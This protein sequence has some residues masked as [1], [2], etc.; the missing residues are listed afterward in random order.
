MSNAIVKTK[1]SQK[2]QVFH[3]D[4][5]AMTSGALDE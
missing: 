2:T 3:L 4:V 1:N 5:S